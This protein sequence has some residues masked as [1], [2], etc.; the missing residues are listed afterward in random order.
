[1]KLRKGQPENHRV[2]AK[3]GTVELENKPQK[4]TKVKLWEVSTCS[5]GMMEHKNLPRELPPGEQQQTLEKIILTQELERRKWAS[6]IHDGITQSLGN[7]NYRLQAYRKLPAKNRQEAQQDLNEIQ[8]FVLEAIAECRGMIDDLRPSILDGIGLVPAVEKYLEKYLNSMRGENN[9]HVTFKVEGAI[10][11]LSP[12]IETTVYRIV[13][14]ASLNVRK[15]A[16]ATELKVTLSS[17]SNWLV[18]EV[19]DNGCGFD[20]KTV[21]AEGDNWGLIGMRE[22]AEVIGGSL[23]IKTSM[24]QGTSIHLEVPI[25]NSRE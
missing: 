12:E 23:Q 25:L 3:K 13:Q 21:D 8:E 4:K 18:A 20:V 14:E 5:E 15:H 16:R 19:A 24:G 7:I 1:M 2:K 9:C 6:A 17:R 11:G 22:R 10:P